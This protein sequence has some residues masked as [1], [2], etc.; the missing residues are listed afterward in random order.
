MLMKANKTF[1]VGGGNQTATPGSIFDAPDSQVRHY[2]QRGLAYRLAARGDAAP[3]TMEPVPA[4]KAADTGPL[5]SD[6]GGIGAAAPAPSSPPGRQPRRRRSKR[7][8]G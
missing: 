7:S 3:Q 1:R 5:A 8:E 6:G 2:E 4:N